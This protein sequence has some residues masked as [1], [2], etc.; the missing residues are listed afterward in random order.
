MVPS[1]QMRFYATRESDGTVHVQNAV[2]GFLGQHHVHT[3]EE[4][5]Q[6]SKD[7]EI[8]WLKNTSPCDCGLKP[9]EAVSRR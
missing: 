9:G 2:G 3:A 5:K 7:E 8:T 1:F 4:F 6:W